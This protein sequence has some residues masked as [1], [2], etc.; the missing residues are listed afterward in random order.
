M[1]NRLNTHPSYYS[2][3]RLN[4]YIWPVILFLMLTVSCSEKQSDFK[5]EVFKQENG[6]GY[7]IL[8]KNKIFI[9]QNTI[10]AVVGNKVFCD[11]VDA[12]KVSNMVLLLLKQN[13]MPTITKE[14]IKQMQVKLKCNG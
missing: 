3:N 14:D 9:K 1:T 2:L 8:V 7:N 11:S 10:P 4:I 6:Y 13:K 5:A 12:L